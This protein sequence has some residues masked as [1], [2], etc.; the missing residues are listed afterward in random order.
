MNAPER[1]LDPSLLP[2]AALDDF[3]RYLRE[4]GRFPLETW[5]ERYKDD[6]VHRSKP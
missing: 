4:G 2:I 1:Y 5:W 3:G 6:Y